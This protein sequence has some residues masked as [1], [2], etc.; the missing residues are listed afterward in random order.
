MQILCQKNGCQENWAVVKHRGRQQK[1][2]HNVYSAA[3]FTTVMLV[4]EKNDNKKFSLTMWTVI[5]PP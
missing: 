1:N 4:Y 3:G 2:E 5:G